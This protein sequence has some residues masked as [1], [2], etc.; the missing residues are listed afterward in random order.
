MLDMV[1]SD[2]LYERFCQGIFFEKYLNQFS[3]NPNKWN[4]P[5]EMVKCL[6]FNYYYGINE[7]EREY[8]S[9]S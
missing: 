8:R 5:Q 2:E 4:K 9:F 3:N 1:D 7:A 6:S